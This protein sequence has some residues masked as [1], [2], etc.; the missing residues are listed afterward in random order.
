[1]VMKMEELYSK[2]LSI[3]KENVEAPSFDMWFG[4]NK[5][6]YW[7]EEKHI[8]RILV[9]LNAH[10]T[11]LNSDFYKSCIDDAVEQIYGDKI[12]FEYVSEND[13]KEENTVSESDFINTFDKN[14]LTKSSDNDDEKFESNLMS[15]YTFENFIVGDSNK[16]AFLSA[17]NVAE[18]PGQA[19]NPLFIYGRSGIG[20]THLMHAIGNYIVDNT[21]LKVLY[22]TSGEFREEYVNMCS[23]KETTNVAQKFKNKY[24]NIDVL[25]IDDI[26]FLVGAD[27]TQQ[28]FFHTFNALHQKGKQIIISSDRSPNDLQKIEDRLKSRFTWGLAVDIDP[29][30]LQLRCKII[31]SKLRGTY[32]ENMIGDEVIEYIANACTTDVRQLEG[33]INKLMI[34]YSLFLPEKIDIDFTNEALKSYV[35]VNIFAENSVGKIQRIVA[36]YYDIKVE[37]LKSK[38]RTATIAKARQIAMYLCRTQTDEVL[39]RIGMEFG[40]DHSTVSAACNSIVNEMKTDVKLNTVIKEL[41]SKL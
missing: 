3:I 22:V 6:I 20:K 2:I 5:P 11:R 14:E 27:K 33:A 7:D 4:H 26:Q 35:K 38:K 28:E 9:P 23:D 34:D 41:I 37:D 25:I 15:K 24:Q 18:N 19:H 40:K 8:M 29:P 10:I 32:L 1:M 31:R 39:E 21:N 17:K 13:Y 12:T 36:E 16:L 30:E